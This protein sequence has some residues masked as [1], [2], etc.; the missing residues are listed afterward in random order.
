MEIAK[1]MEFVMQHD[2]WLCLQNLVFYFGIH[3]TMMV[4][5]D[6]FLKI[7]MINDNHGYD[8]GDHDDIVDRIK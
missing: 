5:S 3:K 1:T 2:C 4:L 7:M 6:L 8:D